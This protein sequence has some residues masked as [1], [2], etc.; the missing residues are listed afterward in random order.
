MRFAR[1]MMVLSL[2]LAVGFASGCKK[3]ACEGLPVP[4]KGKAL[5][6]DGGCVHK[7]KGTVMAIDYPDVKS[8]DALRARYKK[9]LSDGGWKVREGKSKGM[10]MASKSAKT[11]ILVV[12]DN[13]ERGVPTAVVTY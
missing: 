4:E 6:L 5:V 10:L 8:A 11:I 12:M 1:I 13:K 2:A 9:A 7:D 3:K